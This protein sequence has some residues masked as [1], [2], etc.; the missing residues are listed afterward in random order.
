[1]YVRMYVCKFVCMYVCVCV[2]MYVCMCVCVYVCM[3]VRTFQQSCLIRH[4]HQLSLSTW[5]SHHSHK[6]SLKKTPAALEPSCTAYN[7]SPN[8]DVPIRYL[9]HYVLPAVSRFYTP[10][11]TKILCYPAYV[12]VNTLRN[13]IPRDTR[14]LTVDCLIIQFCKHVSL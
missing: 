2:C 11:S 5:H 8:C 6:D 3:Y 1:M 10:L 13:H 9:L 4:V 12:N 14:V 7:N